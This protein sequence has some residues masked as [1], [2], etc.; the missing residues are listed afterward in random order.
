MS[1]A[2]GEVYLGSIA[3][4][5]AL[6]PDGEP[7]WTFE[8]PTAEGIHMAPT[9]GPDGLL[10]GAF[11]LGIGAF[12]LDPADGSL[13]WSNSGDPQLIDLGN[14]FGPEASFGPSG[15]GQ[16]VDQ[17]Y[18]QMDFHKSLHAFSV[19]NGE[20]LFTTSVVG[21]ISHQPAIGSDGTIY[22]PSF[23]GGN[24]WG[25]QAIEPDNGQILWI[26]NA[27]NGNGM[28]EVQIDSDET[29]YFHVPGHLEPVDGHAAE[30]KW[31][32]SHF[33]VLDRPS[34]SPDGSLLLLGGVPNSGQPGFVKAFDTADG[35]ELWAVDLPGEAFPAGR[36]LAADHARFTPDGST[37]YVSTS[38]VG[39][40]SSDPHSLVFAL[41][42]TDGGSDVTCQDVR[43]LVARCTADGT[44]KFGVGLRDAGHDGES[45]VLDLDG[46]EQFTVAI[47]GSRAVVTL[48]GQGGTGQR[49]VT[50]LEP[51]GCLDP[52]VT[53]CQ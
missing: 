20:Q 44:L 45:V 32:N 41:D 1:G 27:E 5:Y 30:R 34:L 43:R 52:V 26:Y 25:L 13:E 38:L 48:E 15:P 11:D 39:G 16:P 29:L 6:S 14:A 8:D 4:I 36:H 37:A 28:S 42:V 7:L 2:E 35:S 24:G 23:S 19:E 50:L 46:E 9:P 17:F 3:T 31:I 12:A 18:V 10:Y 53:T 33:Q 40:G 51:A 49:T 22:V 21:S 47:Q